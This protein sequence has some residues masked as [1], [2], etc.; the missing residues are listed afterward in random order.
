M[1]SNTSF[2]SDPNFHA[3]CSL[4]ISGYPGSIQFLGSGGS[5]LLRSLGRL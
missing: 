5:A 3:I 1:R 4:S 2:K